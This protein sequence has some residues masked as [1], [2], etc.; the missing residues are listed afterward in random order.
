MQRILVLALA[1]LAAGFAIAA[2]TPLA[3]DN[4]PGKKKGPPPSWDDQSD[5][6]WLY[7]SQFKS[8]MRHMW[9]DANRIVSAGRGDKRPNYDEIWAGAE[10]IARRA[11]GGLSFWKAIASQADMM[12]MALDD[13][14]RAGAADEFRALGM[15]CDGCHM[16]AWSPAYLHVT[17]K[18]LD[19]WQ[20]NRIKLGM[21]MEQDKEPPP[22]IPH[23]K[24]MQKL[25]QQYQAA[26][27]ALQDWKKA[28]AKS[29]V[30]KI[31]QE[32]RVHMVFWQQVLDNAERLLALSKSQKHAGMAEAYTT[33]ITACRACHSAYAGPE[34]P[35][36][37]P[38]PWEGPVD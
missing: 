15:A 30:A 2:C 16:A 22:E 33:M 10:D 36:H 18:H 6:D 5:T 25:W 27:L 34:R 3:Q 37:N 13:D 24:T 23:R 38:M 7:R 4:Q 29:E 8:N 28:E 14:D 17:L 26:Q 20:Q 21:E 19:A 12:Q 1:A 35:V 9:I 31:G 11:R 32:A